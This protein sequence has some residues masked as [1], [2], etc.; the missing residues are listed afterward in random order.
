MKVDKLEI[1][2]KKPSYC[3]E[4][5]L[6]WMGKEYNLGLTSIIE[7]QPILFSVRVAETP[8]GS[9]SVKSKPLIIGAEVIETV[10]SGQKFDVIEEVEGWYKIKCGDYCEGW[11]KSQDTVK[12]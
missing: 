7:K 9:L 4:V 12:E 6:R 5:Y 10:R 11:V 1:S 8:T 2:D 3:Q